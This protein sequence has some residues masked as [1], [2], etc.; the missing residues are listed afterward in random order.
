LKASSASA[1][2]PTRRFPFGRDALTPLVVLIQGLAV[3]GTLPGWRAHD[4]SGTFRM[5]QPSPTSN[6]NSTTPTPRQ[7]GMEVSANGPISVG[8]EARS[9]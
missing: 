7:G 1:A 6:E 2:G 8:V 3:A 4:G 9:T 5:N